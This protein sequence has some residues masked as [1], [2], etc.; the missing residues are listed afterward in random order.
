MSAADVEHNGKGIKPAVKLVAVDA[1]T[2]TGLMGVKR[3]AAIVAY[4]HRPGTEGIANHIAV[5]PCEATW[6][7]KACDL[8][9]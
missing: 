9:K 6:C 5:F 7:L 1:A 4:Q 8:Q 3:E 2:H